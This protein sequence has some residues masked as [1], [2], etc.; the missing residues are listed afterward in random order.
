LLLGVVALSLENA[1]G[2]SIAW[3]DAV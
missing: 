1:L 3:L 2:E